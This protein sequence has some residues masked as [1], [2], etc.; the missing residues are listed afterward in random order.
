VGHAAHM[1]KMRNAY[2]I[3]V[4]KPE[5][6]RSLGRSSYRWE[7]NTEMDIREVGWKGVA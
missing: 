5:M 1:G 4:R 7:D 3:L 2:K 6:K